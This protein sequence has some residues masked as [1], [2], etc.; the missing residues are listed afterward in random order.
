MAEWAAL[1][2]PSA[3]IDG[4]GIVIGVPMRLVL[5]EESVAAMDEGRLLDRSS[6]HLAAEGDEGDLHIDVGGRG[7]DGGDGCIDGLCR[8]RPSEEVAAHVVAGPRFGVVVT[9]R[10]STYR[11]GMLLGADLG[12]GESRREGAPVRRTRS[13]SPPSEKAATETEGMPA[14]EWIRMDAHISS[15][16]SGAQSCHS[17]MHARCPRP[18]PRAARPT[19]IC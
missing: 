8:E 6:V 15:G 17:A 13:S 11:F 5:P 3:W 1:N 19:W 7:L 14:C 2:Q 9:A 12:V 16:R 4:S 10:E 18:R